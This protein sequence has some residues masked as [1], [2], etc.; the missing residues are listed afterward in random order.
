MAGVSDAP[1]RRIC[2]EMG[3]SVTYSEMISA[4]ALFYGD[5]KTERLLESFEDEGPFAFQ[6]FGHEPDVMAYA[7]EKLNSYPNAILDINMGCPVPKIVKNGEGSAL[8]KNPELCGD[9]VRAVVKVSKKPVT[10]KIRAGFTDRDRN[11]VDVALSLEEAGASAVAV[12]G[13]TREQYYSGSADYSIIRRVKDA[14]RIPVIGNGDVTDAAKA[15]VIF[16]ETGCDYIMIARG[17]EGN[18]WIFRELSAAWEGKDIPDPPTLDERKQMLR[19]QMEDLIRLKGEYTAVR[20][21]RKVT[22]WYFR[23]VPGAA[24]LRGMINSI[25]DADTW[26]RTVDLL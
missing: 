10:A 4:K 1:M 23:G 15:A 26:F 7:A 22:G 20:E 16:Q 25:T 13:R 9:I 3:A 18:P 11:A 17:A 19:R 8:M 14:L 24:K 21:I 6:I 12:H 2:H 5:R